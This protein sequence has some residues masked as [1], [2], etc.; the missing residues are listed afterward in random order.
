[1]PK[2][3]FE[4]LQ[5][6]P[7]LNLIAQDN[8][9]IL[10]LPCY[11]EAEKWQHWIK[12]ENNLIPFPIVDLKENLFFCKK[13]DYIP[14]TVHLDFFDVMI[15]RCYF[16][17]INAYF[18]YIVDDI[19]NLSASIRKL[20]LF[21]DC[22]AQDNTSIDKR[23][24]VT[25]LEYFVSICR[26]IFDYLH[27][28]AYRILSRIYDKSSQ[29][30]IVKQ[31]PD[32]SFSKIVL[33]NST[34]RTSE[35]IHKKWSIPLPFANFYS[36]QAEFFQ[37]IRDLRVSI[38]H[39]G[40][41]LD[42]VFLTDH[43]FAIDANSHQYKDLLIWNEKNTIA[44]NN[45]GSVRSFISHILQKTLLAF[46]DFAKALKMLNLPYDISPGYHIYLRGPNLHWML[47]SR[48]YIDKNPWNTPIEN[49]EEE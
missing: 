18:N 2:S 31:I 5:D 44:P 4:Q 19:L 17:D 15:K 48:D 27:K 9:A 33:S 21:Y 13:G 36:S 45:L 12:L 22:W 30:K 38:V 41:S 35:Q 26:D 37:W 11:S 16:H 40:K 14:D 10:L 25:E 46:E 7:H 24:V 42:N 1:M 8:R 23:F 29:S 6:L 43:G 34:I 32:S 39:H 28:V 3:E 49:T 20:D 47:E